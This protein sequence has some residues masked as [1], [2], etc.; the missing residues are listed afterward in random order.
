MLSDPK[1][2]VGPGRVALNP[3][4]KEVILGGIVSSSILSG[5]FLERLNSEAFQRCEVPLETIFRAKE[6][7][8][9]LAKVHE[10]RDAVECHPRGQSH[11]GQQHENKIG[12]LLLH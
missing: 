11:K 2:V 6:L 10:V 4:Q 12:W 7:A 1:D 5:D 3:N 9:E 8:K